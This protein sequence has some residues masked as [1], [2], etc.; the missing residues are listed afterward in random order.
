MKK[1]GT[2]IGL[3]LALVLA[4]CGQTQ[5]VSSTISSSEASEVSSSEITS[6]SSSVQEPPS[7][8]FRI[9]GENECEVSLEESNDY[10]EVSIPSSYEGIPVTHI[11][12]RGFSKAPFSSIVIPDSVT[13][14]GYAAFEN[15]S[16]L[17][18]IEL[19]SSLTKIGDYAFYSCTALASFDIP[20]ST[21]YIGDSAFYGCTSLP[22]VH[23]PASVT[24][25]RYKAF[26]KCLS[27]TAIT[28][29]SENPKFDSRDNYRN[30]DEQVSCRL[31]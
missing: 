14:I 27:L 22:S 8:A 2:L 13:T 31:P 17:A 6:S 20:E 15:C 10:R 1:N 4:S 12:D 7:F 11:A 21:T 24:D 16:Y 3:F 25:I 29:D 5:P 19:P 28:V 26:A 18:S 23:I 30:R 9:I